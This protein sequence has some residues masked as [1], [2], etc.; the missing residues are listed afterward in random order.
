MVGQ[1]GPEALGDDAVMKSGLSDSLPGDSLKRERGLLEEACKLGV[2]D[3]IKGHI[4]RGMDVVSAV[5]LRFRLPYLME[6]ANS[7]SCAGGSPRLALGA[8]S[9]GA[10]ATPSEALM[11]C[12]VI[13][14]RKLP[15]R[16][17]P[18]DRCRG[19]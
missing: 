2:A 16:D 4:A 9:S 3:D 14:H 15:Q 18:N 12:R 8:G 1:F 7:Y 11:E 6:V 10:L 13:R 19:V 17:F 5:Q